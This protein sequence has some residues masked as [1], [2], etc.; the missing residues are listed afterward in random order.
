MARL[1][2]VLLLLTCGTAALAPA[3]SAQSDSI[4]ELLDA[5]RADGDRSDPRWFVTI[6]RHG[7]EESF[8]AL[9]K[10][11]TYVKGRLLNSAY[12]AF[13][14]YDQC[15]SLDQRA[16]EFLFEQAFHHRRDLNQIA[17]VRALVRFAP[18]SQAELE[19]V[20]RKHGQQECRELALG[21]LLAGMGTF[22]DVDAV[23]LILDHAR[24]LD[25]DQDALVRAALERSLGPKVLR[26]LERRLRER[27][28]S[29]TWKLLLLDLLAG[30]DVPHA[31]ALVRGRILDP[32][33]S[34]QVRA[35]ELAALGADQAARPLIEKLLNESEPS[36]LREAIAA[37]AHLCGDEASWFERVV[38]FARSSRP[39]AR[40]GAAVAL[41]EVGTPGAL[42]ELHRLLADEDWCVRA[43]ALR[44]VGR[45]RRARSIQVLIERLGA[46]RA[47]MQRDV[48]AVL[49]LFTGLD[50]GLSLERWSRWWADEG[51]RFR[52]PPY[53][54]ALALERERLARREA[55]P[56]TSTF[57]GLE[58]VSDRVLFLLDCSGSM[59]IPAGAGRTR[60]SRTGPTR[61]D[62]AQQE[63]ARALAAFPAGDRFNLLFFSDD[64]TSWRGRLVCMDDAARADALAFVRERRPLRGTNIFD[65]LMEAFGDLQVDTIYLLTDGEAT[66]GS[67]VAPAAIRAEV[68]RANRARHIEINTVS[69]GQ[70]SALLEGLAADS[71]GTY[72]ESL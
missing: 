18:K 7:D 47:R 43:E 38:R 23:E 31:A 63:L 35:I 8:D 49:R 59:R 70:S 16:I 13:H 4:E 68:A 64:A 66:S 36:V 71:G 39:G 45:L 24:L 22:D 54:Q 19:R 14:E 2:P 21:P 48:A 30:C 57:Y 17:A 11:T 34:V 33:P 29:V 27:S 28:T 26:V 3:A 42:E 72:R 56:T 41:V 53:E 44:Q 50:L 25:A 62:V 12:G 9:R 5:I 15:P 1:L 46:E 61:M 58:V 10:S 67:I 37:L 32:E 6:A 69:V 60:G 51:A 52:P 40:M 20:L 55:S 65:A